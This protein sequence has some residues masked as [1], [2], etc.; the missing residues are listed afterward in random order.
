MKGT[1]MLSGRRTDRIN[2]LLKSKA[3]RFILT[4]PYPMR[5]DLHRCLKSAHWLQ[6]RKHSSKSSGQ[7]QQYWILLPLWLAETFRSREKGRAALDRAFINDVLWAQYCVFQQVRIHDDLL[8]QQESNLALIFAANQF[9]LEADRVLSEHFREGSR[10]WKTYRTLLS[11]TNRAVVTVRSLQRSG[12]LELGEVLAQHANV[13]AI[14]KI[15]SAAI[16]ARTGQMRH[17]DRISRF[18]DEMAQVGQA[19]DDLADIE[20]DLGRGEFNYASAYIL[21][22]GRKRM[23]GRKHAL[24]SISQALMVG[25]AVQGFFNQLRTH[26]HTARHVLQPLEIDAA[27]EYLQRYEAAITAMEDHMHR[28]RVRLVFGDLARSI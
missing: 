9:G 1:T 26:L 15:G 27:E 24:A 21:R 10:F 12:T 23:P 17:F 13:C 18:A 20:E 16:C 7:S 19:I 11:E 14:F 2:S 3:E 5:R 28:Q 8:D 22:S 6:T 25:D 4:L